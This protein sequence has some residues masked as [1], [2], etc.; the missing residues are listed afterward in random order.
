MNAQT[1][2]KAGKKL[3]EFAYGTSMA[4]ADWACL[5]ATDGLTCWNTVTRHGFKLARAAQTVW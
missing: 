1:A 3:P 5:S 2:T 4:H